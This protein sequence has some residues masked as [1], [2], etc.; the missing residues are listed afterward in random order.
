MA[1]NYQEMTAELSSLLGN[2]FSVLKKYCSVILLPHSEHLTSFT[3]IK[4]DRS[5]TPSYA[6]C[7]I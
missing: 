1:G 5:I 4:E 7:S 2:L 6:W 3:V